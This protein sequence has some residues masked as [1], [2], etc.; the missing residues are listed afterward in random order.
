[1][2]GSRNHTARIRFVQFDQEIQNRF[3]VGRDLWRNGTPRIPVIGPELP[4][5]GV[6]AVVM[7]SRRMRSEGL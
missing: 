3:L 4:P 5:T 7:T 1:M 2:A 6:E